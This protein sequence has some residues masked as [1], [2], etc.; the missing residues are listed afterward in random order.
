[1]HGKIKFHT[2]FSIVVANMIGTGVFTSLGFQIAGI[3]DYATLVF[4]WILGGVISLCGAFS[5][6]ELGAAMPQSGGEYNYLSKI[7]HPSIGF[8][9]GW[10]SATI[11]FAAPIALAA[12][13]LSKYTGTIFPD[14]NT[15]VPGAMMNLGLC[16]IDSHLFDA[17]LLGAVVILIVTFF[18]S[19]NH[20]T[21]GTFQSVVTG[22]KILLIIAFILCG[23]LF[24]PATPGISFMPTAATPASIFS[25]AFVTSM[26]FV[27][28]SYS[29]W[30]ASA[31]IA[32]EIENPKK[33]IPLS[34]LTGTSV[35]LVLY[36]LI[37]IVFLYVTPASELILK[38]EVG[39]E[40][41]KHI[42]GL[43]GSRIVSGI[44]SLLLIS[45]ISSMVFA[46]PRVIS[47]IGDDFSLFKIAARTNRSGIPVI[48]IWIQTAIA[49][50]L[51]FSGSFEF[52]LNCTTF[53]LILFSTITVLGVIVLRIKTPGLERPYR[54]WGYPF[55]PLLFIAVNLWFLV[56]AV[57]WK[58]K[59]SLIGLGIVALGLIVYFLAKIFSKNKEIKSL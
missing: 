8:L 11:G 56:Y 13:A 25:V 6:A 53:V 3:H 10:V 45:T 54:T 34:L 4:L 42:F 33:N 48:A 40:A 50:I 41:G 30:N 39:F 55:T 57:I 19:I 23:F 43:N 31:Y 35:V 9:S 2:A 1:M 17:K 16:S 47:S 46:G 28:F 24:A 12:S 49:L 36:V 7:Y 29:G 38:L 26:F 37:N 14:F 20:R 18:Q 27:A 44:I 58:Q 5:Y 15:E 59:E 21:S 51:L 32:G 52:I 22:L